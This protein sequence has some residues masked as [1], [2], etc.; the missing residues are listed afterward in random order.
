[1]SEKARQRVVC[2]RRSDKII[3]FTDAPLGSFANG[4]SDGGNT[5]LA[6]AVVVLGTAFEGAD[7]KVSRPFL[8]LSLKWKRDPFVESVK[9]NSSFAECRQHLEKLVDKI[10]EI[11]EKIGAQLPI[12]VSQ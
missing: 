10:Y 11:S 5:G 2:V 4:S 6:D 8:E 12:K 1:M 3:R 9:R 7:L